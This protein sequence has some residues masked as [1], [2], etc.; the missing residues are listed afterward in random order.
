MNVFFVDRDPVLAAQALV[1]QHVVKMGLESAQLLCNAHRILDGKK[2]VI[3]TDSK[4]KKTTWVMDGFLD[5]VL[6]KPTHTNH[7]CSIW[8]RESIEN[9]NWL[10]RHMEAL[11]SEYT[12]RYEKI[13]K[14]QSGPLLLALSIPPVNIP[15]ISF[16]TPHFAMPDKYIIS[17]DPVENYRNYYNLGKKSLHKW[18]IRPAPYWITNSTEETNA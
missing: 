18:K 1:N 13:H 9:Y 10:L 5:G 8:V 17:D 2:T 3:R 15:K 11:L 7:P 4:R 6:Y 12:L 14:I 16:T